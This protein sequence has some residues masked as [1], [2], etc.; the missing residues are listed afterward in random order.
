MPDLDPALKLAILEKMAEQLDGVITV[1]LE[2]HA[3]PIAVKDR[4]LR[5]ARAQLETLKWAHS[6]CVAQHPELVA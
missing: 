5:D 6:C 4:N 1:I 2:S 3:M